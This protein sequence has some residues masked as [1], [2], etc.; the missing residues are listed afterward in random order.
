MQGLLKLRPFEPEVPEL[1][2]T[3]D[4]P[5]VPK[6]LTTDEDGMMVGEF[7][8][9]VAKD[10]TEVGLEVAEELTEAQLLVF[11]HS[12]S[13]RFFISSSN[14]TNIIFSRVLPLLGEHN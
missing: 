14:V 11:F 6:L 3:D 10:L 1:F 8:L 7:G 5:E 12:L 9:E 13:N 4:E 2:T